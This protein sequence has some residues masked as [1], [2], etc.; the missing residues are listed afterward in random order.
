V[1]WCFLS[2]GNRGCRKYCCSHPAA[3]VEMTGRIYLSS[4][5]TC[6]DAHNQSGARTT[7]PCHAI[8]PTWDQ[9]RDSTDFRRPTSVLLPPGDTLRCK[10]FRWLLFHPT[11]GPF[12]I[13]INAYLAGS[14]GYEP[15]VNFLTNLLGLASSE[16]LSYLTASDLRHFQPSWATSLRFCYIINNHMLYDNPSSTCVTC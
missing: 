4:P 16:S 8:A 6:L 7:V 12:G 1:L 9:I 13:S 11:N 5:P 2:D 15:Y 10:R 14:E 3:G